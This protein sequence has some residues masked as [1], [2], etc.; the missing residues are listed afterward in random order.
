VQGGFSHL[1]PEIDLGRMAVEVCS[2]L[3]GRGDKW[4]EQQTS[5]GNLP[6]NLYI[7]SG[8][9]LLVLKKQPT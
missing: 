3:Y 6:L 2:S 5:L 9:R 1:I 7:F 8:M 4:P